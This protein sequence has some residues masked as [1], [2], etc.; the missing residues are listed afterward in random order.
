MLDRTWNPR[1]K[2]LADAKL[3]ADVV[4][5]G[6]EGS[7]EG[8]RFVCV[9]GNR[10]AAWVYFTA[11]AKFNT[12]GWPVTT[13]DLDHARAHR[14]SRNITGGVSTHAFVDCEALVPSVENVTVT[15][16]NNDDD[17]HVRWS[18][19]DGCVDGIDF[20]RIEVALYMRFDNGMW[21]SDSERNLSGTTTSATLEFD[22]FADLEP[23]WSL[24]EVKLHPADKK[25]GGDTHRHR[26][27]IDWVN[28][29]F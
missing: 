6:C 18:H 1:N 2:A 10:S 28:S 24:V 16:I 15:R 26:T 20:D 3:W 25:Y 29:P 14:N 22:H 13:Q 8:E 17:F 21:W 7:D 27:F 4:E 5:H 23:V 11:V 9:L 12:K 19:R